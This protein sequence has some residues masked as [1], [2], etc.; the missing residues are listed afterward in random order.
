MGER[1][2]AYDILVGKSEWKRPFGVPRPRWLDNIRIYL[3]GIGW[4][5][6]D[7]MHLAQDREQWRAVVDTVM[8]LRVP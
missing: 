4:K 7:W 5:G 6:V 2:N 3:M 8:N 1:T